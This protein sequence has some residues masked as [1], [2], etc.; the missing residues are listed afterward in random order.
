MSR[1]LKIDSLWIHSYPFVCQNHCWHC[2]AGKRKTAS[3][4]FARVAAQIRRFDKWARQTGRDGLRVT[5][6]IG[7]TFETDLPTL[8]ETRSLADLCG[9][10][11]N[12]ILLG[13]LRDRD[14][15]ELR[16]WLAERRDAG[17]TS[18]VAS[19]MGYGELHDHWNGRHGDFERLL[20]T[21]RIAASLDMELEQ[22]IFLTRES[23]PMLEQLLDTLDELPGK[24][25]VREI[26]PLFYSG[27]ARH[28]EKFRMT[29]EEIDKLPYRIKNL[30]R[31]DYCN[32]RM[33]CEWMEAVRAEEN[34]SDKVSLNLLLDGNNIDAIESAS[35][36]QVYDDLEQRT[37]A[38]Y[39]AIPSRAE[40]CEQ[41]GNKLNHAVY[42][43]RKD[44][45]TKWL[46]EY[47]RFYP[48]HIERNL[49][50]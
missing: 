35:C 11:F 24:V 34:A 26:Y 15:S 1:N 5:N 12:L 46:D 44:I 27:L 9:W 22:R 4:S 31:S 32:W 25:R 42:M 30:F 38:A 10:G 3:I 37:L 17:F 20:K 21:Q 29:A 23:L 40:L 47:L 49:L 41:F 8:K 6:W 39:A 36:Q 28:W 14:E 16:P 7:Y 19:F 13:G 43:F 45:E 33:E 18:V 50:F 2:Q 48:V